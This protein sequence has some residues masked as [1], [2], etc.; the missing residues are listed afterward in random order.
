MTINPVL[1]KVL[2]GNT[3]ESRHRGIVAFAGRHLNDHASLGDGSKPV[4][5]RSAIKLLQAIALVESGAADAFGLTDRE[6]ALACASHNGEAEHVDAARSMLKKAGYDETALE[7]GAHW[8]R[9][10]ADVAALHCAHAEPGAVHN[11]CSGKHAG[12]LALARHLGL[13]PTGYVDVDHPVQAHVRDVLEDMMGV[14]QAVD[15]CGIDGCSVPTYAVPLNAIASAFATI[16]DPSRLAPGRAAAC[17]RLYDACVENPFMVAGTDRFCTDVMT[18]FKGRI[19]LK[20]GAEGVYAAAIR[21]LGLGIA[22]KCDDGAVRAAEVMMAAVID[23]ILPMKLEERAGLSRF[24]RPVLKNWNGIEVGR[25]RAAEDFS[26]L[27]RT[28]LVTNGW[29]NAIYMPSSL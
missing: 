2:R 8:P 29:E 14:P 25:I 24:V 27:L 4:F 1:V 21:E 11:N 7:C 13:D 12:F 5:P 23:A 6:L 15:G 22:L 26:S 9:R 3:L 20:V 16:A 10:D 28:A 18:L 17:R 19:L